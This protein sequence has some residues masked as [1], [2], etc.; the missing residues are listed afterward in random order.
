M[1]IGPTP[2]FVGKITITAGENDA[3]TY[4][5]GGIPQAPV[6]TPGVYEIDNLATHIA[7]VMTATSLNTY[8]G[9]FD[10]TSGKISISRSAGI[11]DFVV[12]N[13]AAGNCWTGGI[14]DSSGIP[15]GILEQGLNNLGYLVSGP[16]LPGATTTS[17]TVVS[18]CWYPNQPTKSDDESRYQ[19]P[20]TIQATSIGG[21]VIT[22]DFAGYK[23][24]AGEAIDSRNQLGS[25]GW[26]F[27]TEASRTEF[28]GNFWGPYAKNGSSFKFYEDKTV[29]SFKRYKLNG[30]S[31]RSS[32][33][34]DRLVGY[35]YFSGS[36]EMI[37]ATT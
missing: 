33:F 20:S 34:V 26:E 9:T 37:R 21:N 13:S 12:N 2:A 14:V 28:L 25:L 7:A 15:L 32:T 18:N 17:T 19:I 4:E 30:D 8:A 22:Y 6:L 5:E 23:V 29:A 36:F 31:L 1:S 24:Q 11:L 10:Q 3:C 27:I 35:K 16:Q